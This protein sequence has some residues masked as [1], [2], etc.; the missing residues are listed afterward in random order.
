MTGALLILGLLVLALI[1]SMVRAQQQM[2]ALRLRGVRVTGTVTARFATA[3][4][5]AGIRGRRITYSYVGPDGRSYRRNVSLTVP[6]F[7]DCETGMPIALYV[8]PD[9]PATSAP[10]WL[11]D[12]ARR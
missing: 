3:N 5:G 1:A 7:K 4:G 10:A 8:L 11:V 2:K 12:G 9:K 6:D